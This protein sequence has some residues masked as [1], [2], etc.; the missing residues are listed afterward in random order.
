MTRRR[1]AALATALT[2]AAG[3][4]VACAD[5]ARTACEIDGGS[6]HIA[7]PPDAVA[8]V[9]AVVYLHGWG[10]SGDGAVRNRRVVDTVLGRGYALIAPNGTPRRG[11]ARGRTWSFH[12]ERPVV[13]DETAFLTAVIDDAAARHGIDRE[14]VVLSGFSIGGSMT[15]YLACAAPAT[16]AAYAPVGGS[17]WRPHPEACAGPVRLLH[18]HGWSDTTVPLEGRY[19]SGLDAVQGDVFHAME[20]WRAANGCDFLRADGF[21]SDGPFWRRRWERCDDGTALELALFPGG[22]TVPDAW[23]G[24]MLDWFEGTVPAD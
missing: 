17:F 12:P 9:P 19:L 1:A 6:Y 3:P 5:A 10:G 16:F 14:R 22:H 24:T 20:T 4:A 15:S 21:A 13:R 23:A 8:P 18:T 2:L 7:L 11:G